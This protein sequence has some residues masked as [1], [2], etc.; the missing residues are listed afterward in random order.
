MAAEAEPDP[1]DDLPDAQ[2][3]RMIE[4]AQIAIATHRIASPRTIQPL[5]PT[6]LLPPARPDRH[7]SGGTC[8][9]QPMQ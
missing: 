9:F 7:N 2:V 8:N 3:L 1:L 4:T 6:R 5:R